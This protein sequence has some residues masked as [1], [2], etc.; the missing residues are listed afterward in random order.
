MLLAQWAYETFNLPSAPAQSTVV[1]ILK[2]NL[3]T[4]LA[5]YRLSSHKSYYP[6]VE[7]KLMEWINKAE[8]Y[9]VPVVTGEMIRFKANQIR[10]EQLED[11]TLSAS[12]ITRLSN[13]QFSKGWLYRFQRRH[14][15][16]MRHIHGEAA[17]SDH[18]T[19]ENGRLH[20][21]KVTSNFAKEDISNM[22]ET[23]YFF[24]T[25]PTRQYLDIVSVDEKK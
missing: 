3:P 4:E 17:S 10:N 8:I 6:D 15:L 14:D 9:E 22:D 21:Q 13:A 25:A 5:P 20:L 2:D 23:V 18:V 11:S 12:D 16:K 24:C 7:K 1:N 19:V